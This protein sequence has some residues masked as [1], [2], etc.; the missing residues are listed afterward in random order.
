MAIKIDTLFYELETRSEGMLKGF[1]KAKASAAS[2]TDFMKKHPLAVTAAVGAAFTAFAIKLAQDAAKVQGEITRIGNLIPKFAGSYRIVRDEMEKIAR[3]TGSSFDTILRGARAIAT[4]GVDGPM[5]MVRSLRL[6]AETAETTGESI[7]SLAGSLDQALDLFQLSADKSEEVNAKLFAYSKGKTTIEELTSAMK[8]AS[9]VVLQLGLTFDETAAAISK[10]IDLGIKPRAVSKIIEDFAANGEAGKA[11]LKSL[12]GE[13]ISAEDAIARLEAA[14]KAYRGTAEFAQKEAMAKFN[15]SLRELGHD[16]LPVATVA[17]KA[18]SLAIGDTLEPSALGARAHERLSE[19]FSKGIDIAYKYADA[20]ARVGQAAPKPTQTATPL[21]GGGGFFG[22]PFT[23][24]DKGFKPAADGA[25]VAAAAVDKLGKAYDG[26]LAKQAK[27]ATATAEGTL[28]D[29]FKGVSEKDITSALA[30]AAKNNDSSGTLRLN[31]L[32][33]AFRENLGGAKKDAKGFADSFESATKA[34]GDFIDKMTLDASTAL[35]ATVEGFD[36]SVKTLNEKLAAQEKELRE[37]IAESKKAAAEVGPAAL[38]QAA[39]DGDAALKAFT[40]NA[41]K[42]RAAMVKTQDKTKQITTDNELRKSGDA[43]AQAQLRNAGKLSDAAAKARQDALA[44]RKIDLD[45][46]VAKDALSRADADEA[47]RRERLAA[48]LDTE[49]EEKARGAAAN[50]DIAQAQAELDAAILTNSGKI[51]EARVQEL[52]DREALYE[53]A[54]NSD[55]ALNADEKRRLIDIA[56]KKLKLDIGAADREALGASEAMTQ[57]LIKTAAAGVDLLDTLGLIP[58]TLAS[59]L[60]QALSLG[61]ALSSAA[62]AIKGLKSGGSTLDKIGQVGSLIGAASTVASIGASALGIGESPAE[63][64]RREAQEAATKSLIDAL[65]RLRDGLNSFADVTISGKAFSGLLAK[66]PTLGAD[67]EKGLAGLRPRDAGRGDPINR[68]TQ[69][70]FSAAGIELRDFVAAA[71]ALGITLANE[72]TPTVEDIANVAKALNAKQFTAIANTFA[73]QL[74]F[75]N[76]KFK[77]FGT[78]TKDQFTG[79]VTLLTDPVLGAPAIFDALKGIDISTTEGAAQAA[80]VLR[81]IF[82][83]FSTLDPSAFNGLDPSEFFNVVNAFLGLLPTTINAVVASAEDVKALKDSLAVRNLI[84]QGDSAGAAALRREQEKE[85]EIAAALAKG[86]SAAEIASIRY[87]QALEDEAAAKEKAARQAEKNEALVVRQLR[88]QGR[89]AE[90]DAAQRAADNFAEIIAATA[91]GFDDAT[92]A[93]I[94]YTQALEESAYQ[95]ARQAEA[96]RSADAE[97]QRASEEAA[98][99]AEDAARAAAQAAADFERATFDRG[100]AGLQRLQD[101]FSLFDVTDPI[102]KLKALV[103]VL[104]A[105]AP[106]FSSILGGTDVATAGGRAQALEAL[107]S[108]FTS[109]GGQG[110]ASGL[111]SQETVKA[112][113]LAAAAAIKEVQ[114]ATGGTVE[115]S[116]TSFSIDR[117]LTE[118][119]GSRFAGLIGTSN[120][121][122]SQ[123]EANTRAMAAALGASIPAPSL[124]APLVGGTATSSGGGTTINQFF[125]EGSQL[126]ASSLSPQTQ[127]LA[128]DLSVAIARDIALREVGG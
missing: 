57:E 75:L 2:F 69:G 72:V 31:T 20:L 78:T 30:S 53:A 126:S 12:T 50:R 17:F 97:N 47:L 89:D 104:K 122:L 84:A 19:I 39:K 41:E 46:L 82:T 21:G 94:R 23:I 22:R 24:I 25:G 61:S 121:W 111:F 120:V 32:L 92:I 48:D 86:Y 98:R 113:V 124:T 102:E 125:F 45:A 79:L 54:V 83:S 26:L 10:L 1:D 76:A 62:T 110:A 105:G 123:I 43:L 95:Q 56:R 106:V 60:K 108:Y 8:Q 67:I 34:V 28:K 112:Q 73:G 117:S 18:L 49:T 7:E 118:V 14:T 65:D 33:T 38:A 13:A 51:H 71:K 63:K 116:A 11:A 127:Q 5:A 35:G 93:A 70:A 36:Q 42:F 88:A 128:R 40:E 80:E 87:S 58:D 52:K 44:Q 27:L 119:T 3:D 103:G 90:A 100:N 4:N 9:P 15:S 74:D 91:A 115:G 85:A 16:L 114:Q 101:E 96:Q 6:I 99:A 64:A 77:V 68:V 55:T 59:A 37:K 29:L 81:G 109:T 107:Q 66:L